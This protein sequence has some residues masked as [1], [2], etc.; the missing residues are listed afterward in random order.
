MVAWAFACVFLVPKVKEIC[1]RAGLETAQVGW[2]WG[3]TFFLVAYAKTILLA[4]IATV[5]V[6]DWLGRKWLG[7]NRTTAGI[8]AWLLNTAVL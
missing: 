2:L 7:P 4:V 3:F 6:C 8:A 1:D 5:V